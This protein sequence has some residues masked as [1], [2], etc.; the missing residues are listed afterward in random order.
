LKGPQAEQLRDAILSAFSGADLEQLLRF[1]LNLRLGDIVPNGPMNQIVFNLI[2][3]VER[4][5]RTEELIQALQRSRPN[6]RQF[7]AVAESVVSPAPAP[8]RR[9]RKAKPDGAFRARL[10]EALIDQFPTRSALA[11][12][13]D[14]TLSLNLEAV[15]PATNL[16]ETVFELIQ[17]AS[18]DPQ[19]RLRPLLEEAVKRRRHSDELKALRDELFGD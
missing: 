7:Q 15:S 3:W 13:V 19:G 5:G 18:V 17:W 2:D 16:T 14:D 9:P 10:R 8:A 4:Q 11:M 1:D 12:L 6:N